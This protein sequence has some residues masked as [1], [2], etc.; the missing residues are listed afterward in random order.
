[1]GWI[2]PRLTRID[3]RR[4]VRNGDSDI[5][6]IEVRAGVLIVSSLLYLCIAN[7]ALA[8]KR[9]A[10]VVGI[11]KYQQVPQ[12]E[13]PARDAQIVAS[14]F[15]KAKFDVV[16]SRQDLGI[17]ELRRVL[18]EFSEISRDADIS[19]IYYAGHGIELNGKNYLIPADAKLLSNFDVEDEA[20]SLDRILEALDDV[21]RL[22]LVIL[23]AC[24]DN[25]F[26]GS[27]KRVVASRSIGR[28]LAK[29]EPMTSDTLIA[30]AAKAGAVASDGD[31]NNSPFAT[32]LVKHIAEP[33]LDLRL[34]FGRVRDDVLKA[35]GNKQ[36]PF[37]Y[38]SL[39]GDTMA[40][41]PE[42]AKPPETAKPADPETQARIDYELAAQVGTKEAW[43][44][45][46]AIHKTGL[47]ANLAR[48]QNAKL[49]TAEQTRRQ[50][51]AARSDAEAQAVRKAAEVQR[52]ADEQAER[53]TLE[54]RR[55]L[56]EEAKKELDEAKRQMAAQAK[57]QLDSA[58]AQLELA[59]QEA[60]AARR[61]VEEAKRQ[62]VL[63]AQ[64]QVEEAR[65]QARQEAEKV[66]KQEAQKV[67]ALNSSPPTPPAAPP[68]DPAMDRADIT[69]LLQAHLKRVGCDPGTTDGVWNE[70]SQ[71]A[72]G[73]FNQN[74]H[75][76]LDVRVASIGTLDVVRSKIDRV[77][78]LIC[79]TGER[80][81]GDRCIQ[82]TCGDGFALNA[83]GAC[84]ARPAKREQPSA[85]KLKPETGG[86]KCLSVAGKSYCE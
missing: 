51:D 13:N 52:L 34:A 44:S 27:M 22:K 64:R 15:R 53:Q 77:C 79:N 66:A 73:L 86:K 75:T 10:L 31:G 40:L 37:L 48:A 26:A 38:G 43:D 33:G 83:Q 72:L 5:L 4:D 21:K 23:D 30:F 17:A 2:T 46:L 84:E 7:P 56:S 82:V 11:S 71:K 59:R 58:K 25:P 50:A 12:L 61:Q 36:E 3:S 76:Q 16:D 80:A 41:V 47:Y 62:A 67:A 39:G 45:F 69:R 9:V 68:P 60:D 55:K 85:A 54:A 63:D 1:V 78:P 28:G 49:A 18:R 14:L 70:K 42:V 74:A 6:E 32:A 20:I 8:M 24:R 29:V 65:N 19:V 81:D 35:T 57:Q